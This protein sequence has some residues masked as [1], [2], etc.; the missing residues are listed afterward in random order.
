M[1]FGK[2]KAAQ[3]GNLTPSGSQ[4]DDSTPATN[5]TSARE[6]EAACASMWSGK[7][8][9]VRPCGITA[10]GTTAPGFIR[11]LS[12]NGAQIET[13][14][15]LAEGDEVHY[16][17]DGLPPLRAR[18]AWQCDGLVGLRNLAEGEAEARARVPRALRVSCR[19]PVR[20][21]RGCDSFK[22]FIGNISQRGV[23]I[24]GAPAMAAGSRLDLTVCGELFPDAEVRWSR[25]GCSGVSLHEAIDYET[26]ASLVE[27]AAAEEYAATGRL[28]QG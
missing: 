1:V 19:I 16:F 23:L 24:Y 26:I 17:W 8:R 2:V 11:H 13:R 21:D 20:I 9:V 14:M 22:G 4:Q 7:L 3:V 5:R 25:A 6:D 12:S 27:R 18:V 28:P 10:R 15:G